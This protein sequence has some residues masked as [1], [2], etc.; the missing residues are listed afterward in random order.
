MIQNV[1]DELI[2]KIKCVSED[3]NKKDE[4]ISKHIMD[5]VEG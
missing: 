3:R 1:N 2:E 5:R 4:F